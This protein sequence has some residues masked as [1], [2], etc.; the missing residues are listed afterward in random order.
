M[1]TFWIV[2]AMLGM[3]LLQQLAPYASYAAE[4]G[5]QL[6]IIFDKWYN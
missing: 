6:Q 1:S 2:V 3:P 4:S 5:Q